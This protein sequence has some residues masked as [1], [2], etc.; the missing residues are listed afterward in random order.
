MPRY[1]LVPAARGKRAIFWCAFFFACSQLALGAYL[2]LRHP[3]LRDPVFGN[4]IRDFQQRRAEQPN[5]PLVLI[6]GSSRA[7]NGIAP[8]ELP[9]HLAPDRPTP[10]VYNFALSGSGAVRMLMTFRR[11]LAVG[12]RPDYLLVE[13]WPPMWCEDGGYDENRIISQDD[14]RWI[15]VPLLCRYLPG[16]REIL[17]K[18]VKGSLVPIMS[19]RA[20]LL[21]AAARFLLPREQA[22][23]IANELNNWHPFDGT[24]WLPV[25]SSPDTAEGLR[26]EVE[27]GR[28]VTV[29]L[30][31]PLRIHTNTDRALR[32]LLDL[33]RAWGIQAAVFLMP[34]HSECRRWYSPQARELVRSYLG[35][36]GR[37]YQ[38]P[39]I[40]TRDWLSDEYFADFCHM[41]RAGAAPFSHRFAREVLQPLLEG[42]PLGREVILS[43][44]HSR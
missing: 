34:E 27:R 33:C 38:V 18:T 31:N 35:E 10:L 39:V 28:G 44:T 30:L 29:P 43:P 13:T 3:E 17:T 25:L 8:A 1:F 14:L 7:M 32:E 19:Y 12:V 16:K 26:R 40:D 6:L 15:D 9:I 21:H 41:A 22:W 24:G 5:A 23:Q 20:R 42:Q 11:L 36:L 4:R 2:Y 37:A